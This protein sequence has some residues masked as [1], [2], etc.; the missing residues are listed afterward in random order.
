MVK[1]CPK[2]ADKRNDAARKVAFGA[3][4]SHSSSSARAHSRPDR[5]KARTRA[6]DVEDKTDVEDIGSS[7]EWD[8]DDEDEHL[9]ETH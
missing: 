4:R 2:L 3:K 5:A 8:D 9:Y 1:N 6:I 7:H